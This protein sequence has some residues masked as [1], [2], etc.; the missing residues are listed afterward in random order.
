MS[1]WLAVA[2]YKDNP[3]L[4]MVE[5]AA[6]LKS[7]NIGSFLNKLYTGRNFWKSNLKRYLA[8]MTDYIN[9]ESKKQ[10]PDMKKLLTY[11]KARYA[12]GLYAATR[13]IRLGEKGRHTIFKGHKWR[14]EYVIAYHLMTGFAKTLGFDPLDFKIIDQRAYDISRSMLQSLKQAGLEIY[15]YIRHHFRTT[16]AGRESFLHSDIVTTDRKNHIMWGVLPESKA[17]A[18]LQGF[19]TL[20]KMQGSGELIP[21]TNIKA[22]TED[23]I[24][25]VFKNDMDVYYQWKLQGVDDFNTHLEAFN[26]RRAGIQSMPF[27]KF[28]KKYGKTIYERFYERVASKEFKRKQCL[29]RSDYISFLHELH[30]DLKFEELQ[31]SVNDHDAFASATMNF[32]EELLK[33][34]GYLVHVGTI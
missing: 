17:I 8:L 16:K 13:A 9:E 25:R 30:S 3:E 33:S 12:I 2:T 29:I 23:D 26:E 7:S 22:V 1:L 6:E 21:G 28:L 4:S 15:L 10:N 24:K 14:S 34:E 32:I 27:E 5:L 20:V 31:A 18:I 11:T 19:D